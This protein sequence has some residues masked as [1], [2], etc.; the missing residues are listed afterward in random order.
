LKESDIELCE[1]LAQ[2]HEASEVSNG[3]SFQAAQTKYLKEKEDI[4]DDSPSGVPI[5]TINE[6]NVENDRQMFSH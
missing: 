6:E 2:V 5:T 3:L 1:V 4:D